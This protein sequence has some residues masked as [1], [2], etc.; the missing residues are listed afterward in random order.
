[1]S[2]SEHSRSDRKVYIVRLHGYSNSQR[3]SV[4]FEVTASSTAEAH[5][6]AKAA[7]ADMQVNYCVTK[8]NA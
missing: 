3:F 5:Q 2:C 6:L 8:E 7:V 1:M 4:V